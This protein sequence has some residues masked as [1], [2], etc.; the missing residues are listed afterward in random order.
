LIEL[1]L[2]QEDVKAILVDNPRQL[3]ANAA[4]LPLVKRASGSQS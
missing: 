1:G 4:A 2:P 3:F